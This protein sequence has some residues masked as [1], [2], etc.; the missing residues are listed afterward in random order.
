MTDVQPALAASLSDRYRIE[1]LV[2]AG[3]MATVYRARDLK[4]DRDVAI[5]TLHPDLGASLGPERFLAEIR[6]TARLQHPHILPLL[7]SGEAD[8]LLY[9]VMPLVDGET[10]RARLD[11]EKQLPIDDSLLIAREVAD[12]LDYA[13]GHGVIHRDIKPE[14]ILLQDG[15]ALVADFGIALAVQQ[16]SGKRITES[17]MSVGTPQYMSPEQAAGERSIGARSDIYSLGAVLYEMLIGEPPFTGPTVQAIVARQVSEPPRSVALQRRAVSGSVD[18]AVLRAL[19]KVPADRFP[20]ARAFADA[21]AR[22]EVGVLGSPATRRPL[23]AGW[24][25]LLMAVCAALAIGSGLAA[26]SLRRT[27]SPAIAPVMRFPVKI[28]AEGQ[29]FLGGVG[30]AFWGRPNSVSIALSPN[31]TLLAYAAWRIA[32]GRDVTSQLFLRKLSD[33]RAESIPGTENGSAPFFSPDGAWIGFFSGRAL[34]RVPVAGGP[35]QTVVSDLG[36]DNSFGSKGATWGEDDAIVFAAPKGLFRVPS[37]GGNATLVAP[38]D[39]SLKAFVR[40]DQPSFLPGGKV[41]LFHGQQSVDAGKADI[42]ALDLRAKRVTS[43][44]SDAMNPVYVNGGRLL[45]MRQGKLFA[46]RFDVNRLTV[47]GQAVTVTDDVMQAI[48]MPNTDW[49]SGAGQIAVSQTGHLAYAAGG[50]YPERP[51][52]IARVSPVGVVKLLAIEDREY[53]GVRVSPSGD[54]LALFARAGPNDW[55]TGVYVHDLARGVTPRL[56]TGGFF[57][58]FPTWSPDGQTIAY[59][60]DRDSGV[61]N[62]YTIRADGSGEPRRLASSAQ[63]QTMGAWSPQGAVVYLE[64]SDIQL[65]PTSG[66][67]APLFTSPATER[68]PTFSPDGRWL[69]YTS[70]QTGRIEVYVRPYPGPGTATQISGDG[71]EAPCWSPNGRRLYYLA[72]PAGHVAMMAVDVDPGNP[73]RAGRPITLIDPWT[74]HTSRPIRNYDVFPDGSF[75]V[76]LDSTALN[77]N[78]IT[79]GMSDRLQHRVDEVHVVL[80][81]FTELDARLKQ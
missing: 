72:R 38:L 42:L 77:G 34:K 50:I 16:A 36:F 19:Q 1:Q 6:T 12:A 5:K 54:R 15:H 48:A 32:N 56:T 80:N 79:L 70:D 13:H 39:S 11:R 55:M 2:G 21:L 8:G 25:T 61:A 28:D 59:T 17:G 35:P 60:S 3:G 43:V 74:S 81:F 20:T 9:Y 23:K 51:T 73:F 18:A 66:R 62:V 7:D 75:A 57:N 65:L 37:S 41:V 10:L 30:D 31:G 26:W 67:P 47:T 46:S 14:N 24:P 22:P 68:Y 71:G 63:A 45:F 53:L 58:T 4:H 27:P 52:P 69:A 29:R 33:E 40:Y 64:G 78:R 44:L 76:P 49:D